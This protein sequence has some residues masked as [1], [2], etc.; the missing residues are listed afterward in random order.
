[1]DLIFPKFCSGCSRF[2]N[3]LCSDCQKSLYQSELVCP[4]CEKLA[5]GG[6]THPGCRRKYSLDGLWFLGI[7]QDPLKQVI[8][9][10][11]YKF[12]SNLGQI[13]ADLMLGYWAEFTPSF[14][15]EI[16]QDPGI[17]VVTSVPLHPRR[18]RW[19]GFN[20]SELLG[21]LLAQKMGL[22]YNNLLKR[23]RNTKPQMSLLSKD[24]QLNIKGAFSLA[25]S[26]QLPATNVLLVDDVWT[27][28]STLTECGLVL[29]KAG[30]QKIWAITLAR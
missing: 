22:K 10:L 17:W 12:V 14:F 13:L 6:R 5:V 4:V 16:K 11:K 29:K 21:R 30:A 25:T 27:T 2:G 20:Q 1:M 15:E 23:T 7:Y 3:Y 28:G 24:R 18:E 19:R 9:K 26:N 8:Q